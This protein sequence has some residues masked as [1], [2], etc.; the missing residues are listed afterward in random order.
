[1]TTIAAPDPGNRILRKPT[2]NKAKINPFTNKFGVGGSS[3]TGGKTVGFQGALPQTG[4]GG[5]DIGSFLDSL[6]GG[7]A[8]GGG[9]SPFTSERFEFD[10]GP[11]LRD[12]P[13]I[14]EQSGQFDINRAAPDV[15][16]ADGASSGIAALLERLSGG[17]GGISGISGGKDGGDNP[18]AGL[19][20]ALSGKASKA[21]P[22]T[23]EQFDQN[24]ILRD[25]PFISEQFDASGNPILRAA[26]GFQSEQFDENS[27]LR[28]SPLVSEQFDVPGFTSE[29]FGPG[30]AN[31]LTRAANPQMDFGTGNPEFEMFLNNLFN[32]SVPGFDRDPDPT[33]RTGG[34]G[35][36]GDPDNEPGSGDDP[37]V[38][39]EPNPDISSFFGD[40]N[41]PQSPFDFNAFLEL[42]QG[43]APQGGG[44]TAGGRDFLRQLFGGGAP[45]LDEGLLGSARQFGR[46]A[47]GFNLGQLDQLLGDPTSGLTGLGEL[48]G[49]LGGRTQEFSDILGGND[50]LSQLLGS[51]DL[52]GGG[53]GAGGPDIQELLASIGL[54]PGDRS[55][56]SLFGGDSGGLNFDFENLAKLRDLDPSVQGELDAI[57]KAQLGQFESFRGEERDKLLTQLFGKGVNRS[58]VA[59]EAGGRLSESLENTLLNIE[60][61]AAERSLGLRGD[62]TNRALQGALAGLSSDTALTQSRLGA[63]TS[64]EGTADQ[65]R[66]QLADSQQNRNAAANADSEAARLGLIG[67][68]FGSQSGALA[69]IFGSEA[70][71]LSNLAGANAG[72]TANIFGSRSGALGNAFGDLAGNQVDLAG[73]FAGLAG[74]DQ[75]TQ[76]N[77]LANL[78]GTAGG[79]LSGVNANATQGALGNQQALLQLLGIQQQDFGQRQSGFLTQQ[80]FDLDR[81][82]A[83]LQARTNQN[84]AG[85][86]GASTVDRFIGIM[87]VLAPLF[88]GG[89]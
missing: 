46:R 9:N 79:V 69:S 7:G 20:E 50:I 17:G 26:P 64:R 52:G 8:G 75:A 59:G 80:G 74:Q 66:G 13:F 41:I 51:V 25:S 60:G 43:A 56:Q 85:R 27:I 49:L 4:G 18:F 34:G 47:S 61:Q 71:A 21:S 31:N 10:Q 77:F 76:S 38:P 24:S 1:M 23:S 67:N 63:R 82:I 39:I 16:N 89:V 33:G 78:G 53:G 83:G 45:G 70:G 73:I 81:F 36:E 40:E 35:G 54:S 28:D 19:L 88:A 48:Q 72:A 44:D 14:S 3:K 68:I 11:I 6:R 5:F 32:N 65:I 2:K 42:I 57:K 58:T 29:Q 22:F 84:I 37:N 15:R 62:Q 87:G 12:S 86:G 30:S 55:D